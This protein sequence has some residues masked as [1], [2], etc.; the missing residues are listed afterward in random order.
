[1]IELMPGMPDGVLGFTASGKVTGDDYEA[2]LVPEVEE[3]LKEHKKLSLLYHL[4]DDFTGFD[5]EA[6]W[7][8]TKIGLKHFFSWDRIAIVSDIDWVRRGAQI[9]GFATPCELRVFSDDE[10][11][12]ARD[13]ASR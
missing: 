12:K 7:D 2:V 9:V 6:V 13:W 10:L 1:M 4:G 11:D 3:K 8:D 5:A